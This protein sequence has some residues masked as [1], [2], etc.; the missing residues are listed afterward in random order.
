[1]YL[2][3]ITFFLF[4]LCTKLCCDLTPLTWLP[5]DVWV[6]LLKLL[7]LFVQLLLEV[8][9]FLL[10]LILLLFRDLGFRWGLQW[11]RDRDKKSSARFNGV[12]DTYTRTAADGWSYRLLA[13]L[14]ESERQEG[15]DIMVV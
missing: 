9:E 6:L 13:R 1:M 11:E 3:K 4:L 10:V 5:L 14:S 8:L 2:I 12:C 7:L 15:Q